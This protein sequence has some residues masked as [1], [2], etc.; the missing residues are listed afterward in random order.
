MQRGEGVSRPAA[1]TS[2]RTGTGKQLAEASGS[3]AISVAL[4]AGAPLDGVAGPAGSVGC[5]QRPSITR[6]G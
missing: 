1:L 3:T 6:C 5:G 4:S 2:C